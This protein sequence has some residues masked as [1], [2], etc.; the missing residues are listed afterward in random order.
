M[1]RLALLQLTADRKP[2]DNIAKTKEAIRNA[3]EKGAQIICTQELF[4]T[5]YFCVTQDT[6]KFRFGRTS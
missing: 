5:E 4:T 1:P 6:K 2:V 3:A